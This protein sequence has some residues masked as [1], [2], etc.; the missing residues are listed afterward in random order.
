MKGRKCQA[1][2]LSYLLPIPIRTRY[3]LL[4]PAPIRMSLGRM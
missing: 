4:S 2:N 3:I 1:R